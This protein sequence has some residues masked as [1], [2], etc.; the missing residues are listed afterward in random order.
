MPELPEVHTTATMLNR[1]IV[2]LTITSVWTDYNSD[3]HRGQDNIKDPT[4]FKTFQKKVVGG[5]F[6]RIHRR[7][8]N[9]LLDIDNGNTIVIHMKMTGH[10]LYGAYKRVPSV[11]LKVKSE[12]RWETEEKGPLQEPLNQFIHLVFSLSDGK[13]LALSDLRKFAKVTVI[14]T[15]ELE[16]SAHTGTIGPEPLE[17]AFT[18]KTFK[19]RL[20]KKPAG[21]IKQVL[22]DPVVIAGIGNIYS[23]EILY[24]AAVHPLSIVKKIPE[25]TLAKMFTAMKEILRKGIDFGG[26]STSDYRN[27]L[28]VRG[29]F[30]YHHQAYRNTGKACTLKGCKGTITRI[31]FGGRGAHF[32]NTHQVK[33]N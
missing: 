2:G 23:D 22:M 6:T 12:E 15:A 28:G 25:A 18:F 33:Y 11:K 20:G 5:T 21:K 1:L 8:K 13:K 32:C 4:F 29:T 16:T 30:H 19:E 31:P 17:K 27:P 24:A 26:D 10:L 9:V 14:K 7:G 3:Y